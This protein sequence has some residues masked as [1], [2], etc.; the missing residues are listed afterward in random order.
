[1]LKPLELKRDTVLTNHTLISTSESNFALS[2]NEKCRKFSINI[3]F[4]I[5]KTTYYENVTIL[6]KVYSEYIVALVFRSRFIL[7]SDLVITKAFQNTCVRL[8]SLSA[9]FQNK[10]LE[11][12]KISF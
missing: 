10:P 7:K 11:Y 4:K 3:L 9:W 12:F 8:L 2:L 5:P 6:R 1:M